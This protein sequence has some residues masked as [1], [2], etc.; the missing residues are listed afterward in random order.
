MDERVFPGR[1]GRV[2]C[3][4]VMT[5]SAGVLVRSVVM[6][7]VL[8]VGGTAEVNFEQYG[9]ENVLKTI[10]QHS[11]ATG[12]YK[13]VRRILSLLSQQAAI[14]YIGLGVSKILLLF[15]YSALKM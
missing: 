13:N 3:A 15:R 6:L 9:S 4:E 12:C 2:R 11:G 10:N 8:E 1:D 5:A 14:V 7:A